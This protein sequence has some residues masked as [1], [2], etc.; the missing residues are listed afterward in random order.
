VVD[1]AMSNDVFQVGVT[2]HRSFLEV[3]SPDFKCT[4]S[5]TLDACEKF[6]HGRQ[7]ILYSGLAIGADSEAALQALSRGWRVVGVL[8]L[9]KNEISQEFPLAQDRRTFDYLLAK[10]SEVIVAAPS[11]TA[12]PERYCRVGEVLL[13]K[14]HRLIAV[15][16]GIALSPK[17]GGT[18]WVV[19]RFL[20]R[21]PRDGLARLHHLA[22][23]RA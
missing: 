10:A 13:E 4:L 14:A 16:D 11:G 23:H 18:A 9:P 21:H 19:E 12:S 5:S 17:A 8:A 2:G 15:W 7:P 6:S 22:V 20:T 1:E 3:K